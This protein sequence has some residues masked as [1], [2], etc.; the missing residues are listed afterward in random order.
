MTIYFVI[1]LSITCIVST[2]KYCGYEVQSHLF[3][4]FGNKK[5]I[6][7]HKIRTTKIPQDIFHYSKYFF[8]YIFVLTS[9]FLI[10][11]QKSDTLFI[12]LLMFVIFYMH[13]N[14]S[15]LRFAWS[16]V[17]K[18]FASSESR[19]KFYVCQECG[20][21]GASHPLIGRSPCCTPKYPRGR[22]WTTSV[23][24][25]GWMWH[26]LLRSV[27]G[28]RAINAKLKYNKNINQDYNKYL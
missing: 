6:M 25:N 28:K 12:L 5:R 13:V 19:A 17:V 9:Y 26:F 3:A 11:V 16:T 7:H 1:I 23:R 14:F 18:M 8:I 10:K 21:G 2:S 4:T 24:E 20:S 27:D 15:C 22:Y